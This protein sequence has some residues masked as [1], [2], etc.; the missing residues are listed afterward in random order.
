MAISKANKRELIKYLTVMHKML[1]ESASDM[2]TKPD[3]INTINFIDNMFTDKEIHYEGIAKKLVAWRLE[4]NKLNT[5]VNKMFINHV[6][7]SPILRLAV[8]IIYAFALDNKLTYDEISKKYADNDDSNILPDCKKY[9]IMQ[10]LKATIKEVM[11]SIAGMKNPQLFDSVKINRV[12]SSDVL[13]IVYK[14]SCNNAYI[15]GSY[16]RVVHGRKS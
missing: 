11:N 10:Y 14:C 1:E 7:S 8:P 6:N 12:L 5:A 13:D 4:Y 2:L 3:V 16:K 15:I 9:V